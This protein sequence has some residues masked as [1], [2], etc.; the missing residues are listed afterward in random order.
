LLASGSEGI[1]SLLEFSSAGM[2]TFLLSNTF[3]SFALRDNH[4][5]FGFSHFIFS[6]SPLSLLRFPLLPS[7]LVWFAF[8][9]FTEPDSVGALSKKVLQLHSSSVE[10]V[11]AMFN[12]SAALADVLAPFVGT[13]V[14]V[15]YG[16]WITLPMEHR[17]FAIFGGLASWNVYRFVTAYKTE[18][19]S[20]L[21]QLTF[22]AVAPV[23]WF[24]ASIVPHR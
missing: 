9:T 10:L 2:H 19:K 20:T 24:V 15:I 11:G 7:W 23:L 18:I 4:T 6:P 16:L 5:P 21:F 12:F 3:R 17:A 14:R 22:I 8:A 1:K 13:V